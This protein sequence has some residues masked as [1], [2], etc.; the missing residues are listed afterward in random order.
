MR[1]DVLRIF[2]NFAKLNKIEFLKSDFYQNFSITNA[3][4]HHHIHSY[5][6]PYKGTCR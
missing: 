1:R 2:R 5:C 4:A 3:L 6:K